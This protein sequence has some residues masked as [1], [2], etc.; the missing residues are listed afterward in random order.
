[1]LFSEIFKTPALMADNDSWKTEKKSQM[2][3]SF[4]RSANKATGKIK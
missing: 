2:V 3:E 4:F 1:M